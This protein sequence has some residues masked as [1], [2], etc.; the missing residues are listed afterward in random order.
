MES[1]VD[2]YPLPFLLIV[3]GYT[4]ILFLDK[5]VFDA[6]AYLNTDETSQLDQKDIVRRSLTKA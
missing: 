1:C 6:H 5:V 2:V 4:M 3:L